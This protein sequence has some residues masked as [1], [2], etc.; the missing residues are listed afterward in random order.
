M[1]EASTLRSAA[2][3]G[4]ITA[5]SR[6]VGFGRV[7]VVAAVLGTTYLGNAFQSANSVSNVVFELVAAGA[8]SS[9]LVPV[10]VDL[11]AR[12]RGEA[13]AVAGGVL[14]V[15]MGGLGVVAVVGVAAAPVLAR[16]LTLGVPAEV[17]DD[18][19][20]L[21]SFLLVFFIPQVVLYAAATV[22]TG[23][24]HARQR[25]LAVAAAPIA[26]TVVM[27]GCLLVLRQATDATPTL[28]LTL[29]ERALLAAAGT[30]GVVAFTGVIV[31]AC[32]ASGFHL[33]PRL[34]NLHPGVGPALRRAGWGV[35]LHSSAGVLLA[36]SLLVGAAVEGGV[37]AYQAAWVFFLAPY[38]ILSQPVHTAILPELVVE[39][40]SGDL[41]RFT[42][43]VRWA[44]ER[45]ALALVPVTAVLVAVAAPAMRIVS[46][47]RAG[48]GD[49]PALLAA[50]LGTL[51]VGLLPYGA[52][53]LLARASYAL[54]DSRTPGQVALVVAGAG[55][56]TMAIGAPLTH[57][58]AR[59]ALI[60][61]AHSAAH[62]VGA[63]VLSV[64]LSRRLG[65]P[66]VPRLLAPLALAGAVAAAAA[67]T[68][69]RAI[70]GA[71]PTRAS[72]LLACLGAALVA[73][74]LLGAAAV[75][76]GLRGRLASRSSVHV[77]AIPVAGVEGAGGGG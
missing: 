49:G 9:V 65:G 3:M 71:D 25:F 24:L 17:A 73:T 30:G 57:G 69:G 66:V 1:T 14:G 4:A 2:G 20:R 19:R 12:G 15:A 5:V 51:A 76:G 55:A 34:R 13:E 22:A 21:I 41:E 64:L 54:D 11:L 35:V 63:V 77:A 61:A 52:F 56:A 28:D 53:L 44:V 59:I 37:V 29:G 43:S 68:A 31:I 23:V 10:F 67:W 7:L 48:V 58:T 70:A 39:A 6:V 32:R 60:G 50:A 38:A 27:V 36:G 46:V 18:Q 75:A 72:D 8:L 40:R 74:A 62:L 16:L 47:G 45:I 33:R 42:G 26:N